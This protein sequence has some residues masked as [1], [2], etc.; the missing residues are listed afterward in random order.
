MG[1]KYTIEKL[2]SAQELVMEKE[3]YV[4]MIWLIYSFIHFSSSVFQQL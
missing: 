2:I 3:I 4:R 1:K